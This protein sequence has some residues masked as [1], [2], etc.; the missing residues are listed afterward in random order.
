MTTA[1]G[2]VPHNWPP[3][4]DAMQSVE[5]LS[6]MKSGPTR[7]EW[8]QVAASI[9]QT[10]QAGPSSQVPQAQHQATDPS[11]LIVMH[12]EGNMSHWNETSKGQRLQNHSSMADQIMAH[13]K[14]WCAWAIMN[15][16]VF[17]DD[18]LRNL[19]NQSMKRFQ[20][21]FGNEI[22]PNSE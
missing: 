13:M 20:D 14:D 3:M 10:S 21:H 6:A 15:T 16:G 11:S 17:S 9:G 18:Q 5:D 1:M 8:T 4:P 2:S 19:I 12:V 22:V 7:S